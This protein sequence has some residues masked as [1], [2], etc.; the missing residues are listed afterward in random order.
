MARA[1]VHFPDAATKSNQVFLSLGPDATLALLIDQAAN[2]AVFKETN[3]LR[4]LAYPTLNQLLYNYLR[5]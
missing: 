3:N 2:L 5:Q 1:T 4:R